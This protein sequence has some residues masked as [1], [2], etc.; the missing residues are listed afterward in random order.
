MVKYGISRWETGDYIL[1]SKDGYWRVLDGPFLI[2]P[3]DYGDCD[4]KKFYKDLKV[5]LSKYW[6]EEYLN[7]K[8]FRYD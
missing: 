4:Y 1:M 5:F 3:L 2:L 8:I 7:K 6:D